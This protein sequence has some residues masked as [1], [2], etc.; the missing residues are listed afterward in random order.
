MIALLDPAQIKRILG[1]VGNQKPQAIGVKGARAAEVAH[2]EFDMTGADDVER[3]IENRLA[4]GHEGE[5]RRR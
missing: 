5:K 3:R 2:A 4:D 1:L